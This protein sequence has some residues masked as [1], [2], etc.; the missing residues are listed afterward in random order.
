MNFLRMYVSQNNDSARFAIHEMISA[1]ERVSSAT[2]QYWRG[3]AL[4][5]LS[6]QAMM[7]LDTPPGFWWKTPCLPKY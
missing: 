7:D 1:C 4:L 5:T 3:D 2:V 6:H